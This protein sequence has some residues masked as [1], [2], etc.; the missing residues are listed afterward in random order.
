MYQ[1]SNEL[2]EARQTSRTE[3]TDE[4]LSRELDDVKGDAREASV[5]CQ[6]LRTQYANALS[7]AA[8]MALTPH[9]QPEERG[10]KFPDSPDFSE[11]DRTHLR[12][13][14]AQ[15]MMIIR[16]KP[17]TF[18]DKQSKMRYAF[19]RLSRF[20]LRQI[21]QHVQEHGE[22]GLTD[23]SALIQLLEAAFGDP[24]RVATAE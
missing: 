22:I 6:S 3:G 4:D 2:D 8:R 19:H 10:P 1:V 23:L 21:L 9:H 17:T 5:E 11:L 13:W 12:R 16:H 14:I 20:A 7:L 18:P 24:D 15:H